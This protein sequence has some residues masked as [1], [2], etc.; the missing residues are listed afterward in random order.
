MLQSLGQL[1]NIMIG[2]KLD[3]FTYLLI[4]V[5]RSLWLIESKVKSPIQLDYETQGI[6]ANHNG[7][8]WIY[9]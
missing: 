6:F 4:K 8:V 3:D 9:M 7:E 2:R 1:W 5:P